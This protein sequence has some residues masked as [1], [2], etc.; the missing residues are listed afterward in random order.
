MGVYIGKRMLLGLL[1]MLGATIVA[2][3]LGILSP[4]DPAMVALSLDG[5]SVPT[6][7][8]LEEKRRSL[9]LDAPYTVQYVRWVYGVMLYYRRSYI[10]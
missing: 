7:M 8:E 2:F 1:T 9:S 10:P 5:N 3:I 4:S 6:A